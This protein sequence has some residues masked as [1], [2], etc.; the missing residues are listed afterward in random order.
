MNNGKWEVLLYLFVR[1]CVCSVAVYLSKV[2]DTKECPSYLS[3]LLA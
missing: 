1:A 2:Y 3:V